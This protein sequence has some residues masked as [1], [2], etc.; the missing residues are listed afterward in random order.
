MTVLDWVL[1]VIWGGIAL[2]GFWKGAVKVVFGVGGLAVGLWLALAVGAEVAAALEP[3]VPLEWLSAALGRALP[4]VLSVL[5]FAAAGWGI[6]R[7]LKALHLGWANHLAGAA[8]AAVVGGVL[9]GVL[10][11]LSLGISPQW[12]EL[13]REAKLFPYLVDLAELVFGAAVT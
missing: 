4:L 11:V 1:V 12:A 5:L 2:S 8:L 3:H 9:L 7:T 6:E 10:L 13:C